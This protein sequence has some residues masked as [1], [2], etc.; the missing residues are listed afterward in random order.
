M[1]R[2]SSFVMGTSPPS[3]AVL[4]LEPRALEPLP[5]A[6]LGDRGGVALAFFIYL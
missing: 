4:L 1:L 3:M 6:A 2:S 5:S